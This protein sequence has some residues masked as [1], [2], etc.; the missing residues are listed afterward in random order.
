MIALAL[1][2]FRAVYHFRVEWEEGGTAEACFL[3][4]QLGY[5]CL[6]RFLLR[7]SRQQLA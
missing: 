5:L 6:S 4:D 2:V 7:S 3:Q 1:V